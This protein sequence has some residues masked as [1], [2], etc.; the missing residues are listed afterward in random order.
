MW[1]IV[2]NIVPTTSLLMGLTLMNLATLL[3]RDRIWLLLNRLILH[4]RAMP[5]EL[6][7]SGL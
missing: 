2:N 3:L 5:P 4:R 7:D 6:H 1:V